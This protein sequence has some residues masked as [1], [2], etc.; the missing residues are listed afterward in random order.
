[1]LLIDYFVNAKIVEV[2]KVDLGQGHI[3]FINYIIRLS[4]IPEDSNRYRNFIETL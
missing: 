4:D 1:M 2:T 3:F